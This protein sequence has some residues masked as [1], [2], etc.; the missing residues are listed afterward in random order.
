MSESRSSLR[1]VCV[2]A[3][4]VALIGLTG[5]GCG[6]S[7]VSG[8]PSDAGADAQTVTI[9]RGDDGSTTIVNPGMT[10]DASTP[11]FDGT[12]GA[13][14]QS[15]TD[16]QPTGGTGAN[17]CSVST[18]NDAI[19]PTPICVS[20]SCDPGTDGNAHFCDGPDDPTSPGFCLPVGQGQ[21]VCLPRCF[22]L[23]DGSA[24]VGCRGKDNCV[25]AAFV[26]Q[27]IP[28]AG[29]DAAA[30]SPIAI[31]YCFG[32]CTV[33]AD[34]PSGNSCQA[35]IGICVRT[36]TPPT[37]QLGQACTSADNGSATMPA[38]C[39]CLVNPNTGT[40]YCTHFC[41]VN[42]PTASCPSGYVCDS[43]EPT[44]L[45]SNATGATVPGF[46]TQNTALAGSCVAVCSLPDAGGDG[47]AACPAGATCTV[48]EAAGTDCLP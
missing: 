27:T 11:T 34:C 46:P 26:S 39:N 2:A 9:H 23:N 35:D 21:G 15:D 6:S 32:G 4:A 24:P 5:N 8:A 12:V 7:S 48:G 30:A 25:V 3:A 47:G 33:D 40:G 16:C 14:C 36:V 37:K 10:P 22:A 13:A 20:R 1:S 42:S 43:F 41:A 28:D 18:F 31:G 29:A 17:T 19:F 38:A 45:T 44:T